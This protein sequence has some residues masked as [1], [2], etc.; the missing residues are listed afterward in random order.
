[1]PVL[2][3]VEEFPL[4]GIIRVAPAHIPEAEKTNIRKAGRAALFFMV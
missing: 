4:D 2:R 1:M 3:G